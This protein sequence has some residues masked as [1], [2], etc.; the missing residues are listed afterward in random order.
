MVV[1][2]GANRVDETKV[3][4]LVGTIGKADAK[5]VKER[6]GYSIGGVSPIGH[7]TPSVLLMIKIYC[8]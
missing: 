4:A 2:S 8:N 3:A 7:I 5:F 6:I 1:T